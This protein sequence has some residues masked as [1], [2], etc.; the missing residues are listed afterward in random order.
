[1]TAV[2]PLRGGEAVCSCTSRVGWTSF[3]AECLDD[4][5]IPL[6]CNEFKA[7]VSLPL[8]YIRSRNDFLVYSVCRCLGFLKRMPCHCANLNFQLSFLVEQP[9]LR[10][11]TLSCYADCT[12]RTAV[13]VEEGY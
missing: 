6:M 4:Y 5:V 10:R 1:M 2:V 7:R 3:L 13:A 12:F 8:R 11:R 9:R